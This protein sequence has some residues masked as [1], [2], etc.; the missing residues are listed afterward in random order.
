MKNIFDFHDKKEAYLGIGE[1]FYNSFF[2]NLSQEASIRAKNFLLNYC[3]E[4]YDSYK[5]MNLIVDIARHSM[6]ELFI[7]V[8]IINTRN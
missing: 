8:Y 2:G 6:K 3:K 4:N 1:H 7:A 5:K